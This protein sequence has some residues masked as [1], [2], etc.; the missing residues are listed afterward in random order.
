[1]DVDVFGV[2]FIMRLGVTCATVNENP[3]TGVTLDE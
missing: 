1:L 3:V 2:T